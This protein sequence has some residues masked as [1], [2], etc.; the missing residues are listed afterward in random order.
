MK[1]IAE[2]MVADL[3]LEQTGQELSDSRRWRIGS[4][5][6]GMFREHGLENLE[7]LVVLLSEQRN[8]VLGK[9]TVEAL[10]N[11]E[12]YFFRDR[13]M[14]DQLS[15]EVLPQ[16]AL[17]N[18]ASKRIAIWSA[19]CSTGQE[20]LTLAMIFADQ[21]RR[22][23]G[24]TVDIVATDVSS[25]AIKAAR[26]ARYTQFEI[27]RGLGVGQMLTHF[28]EEPRG[29]RPHRAVHERISFQQHNILEP[30]TRAGR[31]DLVLCRNVLLYFCPAT[32]RRA[33]D[34]LAEAITP[35][36]WLMLGAGETS[37]GQTDAF[38][39]ASKLQGLYRPYGAENR[40]KAETKTSLAAT[41]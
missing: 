23:K 16:I 20:A 4:A 41:G 32:R 10:L 40:K 26:D 11:N 36:G 31:F 13:P 38:I 25:K 28:E 2:Q 7:Q 22:W 33:F 1:S 9:E 29:W 27:Q 19:G 17:R 5:L 35:E 6:S 14:F 39:P 3:L 37:V 12:T 15:N 34:R 30:M 18:A 21:P 24:W 8:D